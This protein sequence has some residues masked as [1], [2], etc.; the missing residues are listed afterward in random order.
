[1]HLKSVRFRNKLLAWRAS[2]EVFQFLYLI[3]LLYFRYLRVVQLLL[4]G[5]LIISICSMCFSSALWHS[6]VYDVQV[7]NLNNTR[8]YVAVQ[9][10][11]GEATGANNH[12]KLNLRVSD[13]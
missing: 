8:E 12:N 1:M 3:C 13:F 2:A 5:F 10:T 6:K 9:V 11:P 4:A 7:P